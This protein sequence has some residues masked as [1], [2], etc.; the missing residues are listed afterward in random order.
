DLSVNIRRKRR[1]VI[2]SVA[3][4]IDMATAGRLESSVRGH[5]DLDVT[6]DLEGVTFMDSSGITALVRLQRQ[7]MD[8]GHTL[9][10]TGERPN[11]RRVLEISGLYDLLHGG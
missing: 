2:V 3:G 1:A 10:V 8:E 5:A 11:V 6:V 7:V 4:E 9:R